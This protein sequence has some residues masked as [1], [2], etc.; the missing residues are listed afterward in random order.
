M[1]CTMWGVT[2]VALV[3]VIHAADLAVDQERVQQLARKANRELVPD[4][5]PKAAAGT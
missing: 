1:R 5:R 4:S 2:F 3:A